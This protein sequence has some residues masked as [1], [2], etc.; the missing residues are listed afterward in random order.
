MSGTEEDLNVGQTQEDE[1]EQLVKLMEEKFEAAGLEKRED[2]HED[3]K[4]SD[5]KDVEDDA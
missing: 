4:E 1:D 3:E 2:Y 5:T